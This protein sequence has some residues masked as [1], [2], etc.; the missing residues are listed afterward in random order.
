MGRDMS[1]GVKQREPERR[2]SVWKNGFF[3]GFAFG[4]CAGFFLL[5]FLM[6]LL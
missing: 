2:E 5:L 6:R 1:F 4:V 3:T